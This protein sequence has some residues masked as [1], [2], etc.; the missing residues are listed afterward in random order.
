MVNN[1]GMSTKNI[2][3]LII[4]VVL[5]VV[6]VWGVFYKAPTEAGEEG[7]G[8]AAPGGGEAGGGPPIACQD[9]EYC[10]NKALY[11]QYL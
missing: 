3:I 1:K 9:N 10:K 7:L 11:I 5:I 2:I 6:L 4:V 8:Q